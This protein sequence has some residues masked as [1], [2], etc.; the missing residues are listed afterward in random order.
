MCNTNTG[1]NVSQSTANNAYPPPGACPGCGYCRCCGR[2][3]GVVTPSPS[4]IN[5]GST[6]MTG[7]HI[8]ALPGTAFGPF[9]DTSSTG[10]DRDDGTPAPV[11]VI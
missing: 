8:A 1:G 2:Y 10:S 11:A 6:N 5:Y 4:V 7:G 3:I 9:L